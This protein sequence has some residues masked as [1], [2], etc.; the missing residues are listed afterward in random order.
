M[1][2]MILQGQSK[3]PITKIKLIAGA[4]GA[5]PKVLLTKFLKNIGLKIGPLYKKYLKQN[6]K[7]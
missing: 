2:T 7:N 4:I 5:D 6:Y 3:L 1:I